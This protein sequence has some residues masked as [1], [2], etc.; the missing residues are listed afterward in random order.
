MDALLE[1]SGAAEGKTTTSP[2]LSGFEMAAALLEPRPSHTESSTTRSVIS[3]VSNSED[4]HQELSL[5][6]RLTEEFDT[7][8]DQEM[9]SLAM[10][11]PLPSSI[12]PSV[13]PL[14]SGSDPLSSGAPPSPLLAQDGALM[15]LDQLDVENDFKSGSLSEQSTYSTAKIGD[16]Q[17]NASPLNELSLGG[18]S[19]PQ[20]TGISVDFSH[21][22]QD[23]TLTAPRP[24]AFKAYRRP[25]E[26][27][28]PTSAP[29][30]QSQSLHTL[31]NIEAPDF[32]PYV[33]GPSFITPVVQAPNPWTTNPASWTQWMI[34]SHAP[35]KP[36][37]TVTKSWVPSQSRLKLEGQV[38]V[39]LR[40]APGSGKSTLARYSFIQDIKQ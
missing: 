22:T 12:T 11:Q 21:L 3:T 40:G 34:P 10:A 8:I 33:E 7:L 6:T 36:S 5:E 25:D 20:E 26:F 27:T 24:S 23:S 39:L 14:P 16:A 4:S 1:L 18:V 29:V 2:L 31:W 35:L 28:K 9:E 38:V 37:A 32:K 17:R 30:P 15:E 13:L 19:L